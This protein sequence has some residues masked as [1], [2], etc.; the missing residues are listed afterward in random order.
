MKF[1]LFSHVTGYGLAP[2]IFFTQF[3]RD[4]NFRQ[5]KLQDLLL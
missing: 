5:W 3:T 2:T 4:F 1:A